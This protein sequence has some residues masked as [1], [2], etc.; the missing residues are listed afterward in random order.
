[1]A[2]VRIPYDDADADLRLAGSYPLEV[3][4]DRWRLYAES[5]GDLLGLLIDGYDH[6]PDAERL[7]ARIRLALDAQTDVQSLLN[8][9]ELFEHATVEEQRVLLHPPGRPPTVREWRCAIPLVLVT[10]FYEPLGAL[11]QPQA[12]GA[13]QTW[14]IDPSTAES[15]VETLHGLRWLDVRLLD[16]NDAWPVQGAAYRNEGTEGAAGY[17]W[18]R[19][20]PVNGGPQR[21]GR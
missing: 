9:G 15:L 18:R 1:M 7:Q 2:A 14:W 13:A 10:V 11:P 19:L 8:A 5:A 20:R 3:V 4:H 12:A 21:G 17:R 16:A 6:L